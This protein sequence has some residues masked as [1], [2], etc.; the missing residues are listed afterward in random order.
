M[1]VGKSFIIRGVSCLVTTSGILLQPFASLPIL[2][3][4]V[5]C[6]GLWLLLLFLCSNTDKAEV[7]IISHENAWLSLVKQ[8]C[9]WENKL[10]ALEFI[11]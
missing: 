4:S 7:L 1:Q 2:L 9:V 5:V 6:L 11:V 10:T 8:D 3:L